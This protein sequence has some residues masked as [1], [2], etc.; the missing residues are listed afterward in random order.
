MSLLSLFYPRS[1][2]ILF[3]KKIKIKKI[4][5]LLLPTTLRSDHFL[6]RGTKYPSHS[7]DTV[8]TLVNE[9]AVELQSTHPKLN[10]H[11]HLSQFF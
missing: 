11:H 8:P 5:H 10:Q 3:F 7:L 2:S 1:P 9:D 6:P 4:K